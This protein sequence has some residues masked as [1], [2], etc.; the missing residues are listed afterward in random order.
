L[1]NISS[2]RRLTLLEQ[3]ET[4]VRVF[5]PPGRP[6]AIAH[7]P[8]KANLIESYFYDVSKARRTFGWFP[9]YS[10]EDMLIDYR[11]EM[12]SGRFAYL[13]EKRR[14]QMQGAASL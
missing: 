4:I 10:F 7:R 8:E 6:S 14:K 12:E 3:A 2:G 13:V 5:S 11:R 9:K 1:Y